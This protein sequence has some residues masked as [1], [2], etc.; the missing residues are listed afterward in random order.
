MDLVLPLGLENQK[1]IQMG[2]FQKNGAW[3]NDY[4][5]TRSQTDLPGTA[6]R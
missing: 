3:Y 6:L 2:L 5:K 1:S 4:E